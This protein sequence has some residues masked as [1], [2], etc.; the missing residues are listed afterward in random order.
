MTIKE[1]HK[2]ID[3]FAHKNNYTEDEEFEYIEALD[4]MIR[5][6]ADPRYMMQ[7]GGYYYGQRVFDLAL[8]YYEMAAELDYEEANEC[9]GYVWYYGRTGTKDYEKAF[10]YFTAAAKRGNTVA[11]YKIADMYKNG[12][13]VEKD[14]E[15]YKK[16]IRELSI[17]CCSLL[18][19]TILY[20]I[21]GYSL[22]SCLNT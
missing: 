7:L 2:I 3:S 19:P 21:A 10:K 17:S 20:G 14:Y 5:S 15:K 22:S 18:A 9:L 6:S 4:F 1:A 8:K 16:L 13:F 12:Y 11:K